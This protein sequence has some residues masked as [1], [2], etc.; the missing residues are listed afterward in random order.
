MYT[1]Q[2]GESHGNLKSF[3]FVRLKQGT[4][5]EAFTVGLKAAPV[6]G[7]HQSLE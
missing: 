5:R 4:G 1:V 7:D 3:I 2:V 6:G